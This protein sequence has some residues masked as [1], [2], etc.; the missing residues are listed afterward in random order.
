MKKWVYSDDAWQ[1]LVKGS[2]SGVWQNLIS[3]GI[4][5]RSS[6]HIQLLFSLNTKNTKYSI[7]QERRLTN[8]NQIL[9]T[10]QK[11]RFRSYFQGIWHPT[12]RVQAVTR[13]EVLCTKMSWPVQIKEVF[14]VLQSS[15][16]SILD[17]TDPEI[18]MHLLANLVN[19]AFWTWQ[20]I[21]KPD[22]TQKNFDWPI[23]EPLYHFKVLPPFL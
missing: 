10:K 2:W 14:D 18:K 6:F 12:D 21:K 3:N 19:S 15:L 9:R 22:L 1:R 5:I 16:D 7:Q 13:V 4:Q 23:W 8:T 20:Q 17:P 11:S